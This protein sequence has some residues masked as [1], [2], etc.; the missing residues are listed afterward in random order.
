MADGDDAVGDVFGVEDLGK[1]IGLLQIVIF[2][3]AGGFGT[4]AEAEDVGDDH[5]EVEFS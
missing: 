3:G 5:G 1:G 4:A 2:R